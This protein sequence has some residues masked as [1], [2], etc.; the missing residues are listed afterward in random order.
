MWCT[1]LTKSHFSQLSSVEAGGSTAFIYGNFSVPVVEVNNK[2]ALV[3]SN[4]NMVMVL[5]YLLLYYCHIQ[6][7]FSSS[8][9]KMLPENYPPLQSI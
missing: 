3:S 7:R 2:N 8:H 6:L 5:F 9:L 1:T 4:I